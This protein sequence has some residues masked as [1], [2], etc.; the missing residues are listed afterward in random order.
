[1][2]K[3]YFFYG[4]QV[5]EFERPEVPEIVSKKGIK[6]EIVGKKYNVEIMPSKTKVVIVNVHD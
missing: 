6:L 5:I 3:Y 4:T 1:M 2:E